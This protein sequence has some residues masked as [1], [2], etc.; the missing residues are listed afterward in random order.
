MDS[1]KY[2]TYKQGDSIPDDQ[3][4][5]A[6]ELYCRIWKEE[7]WKEDWTIDRATEKLVNILK[8]NNSLLMFGVLE[9][10]VCGF[11]GGKSISQKDLDERTKKS[12]ADIITSDDIYSIAEIGV[13]SSYRGQ[14]LGKKLLGELI[15]QVIAKNK[16]AKF[17]LH[18]DIKAESAKRLY[19]SLGFK[20]TDI[21]DSSLQTHTYWVR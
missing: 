11:A 20:H 16:D 2:I 10:K 19:E 3:I 9:N 17:V 8:H 6:A 15:D 14:G 12:L 21:M 4:L 7:P 13:D 5:S 18:T 1:I